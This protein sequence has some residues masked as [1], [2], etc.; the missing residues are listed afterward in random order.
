VRTFGRA[1]GAFRAG[2]ASALQA[3]ERVIP[4][5]AGLERFVRDERPDLLLVTPLIEL[6]SQQVDYVKCARRLGVR[7]AHCVASWDNL[8]SKGLIRVIPDHVVVWNEAQK[9]EAVTLHGVP[10]DRV[11]VT[12]AQ[13]FDDW[14]EA[15]PSRSRDAFCRDVGL[16]PSRP[17]VLYA[18][19]STFIAPDEVPFA[20]RWIATLRRSTDPVV[21]SAG[22]LIRP[23]PANAR[24]W[25]AFDRS[26]WPN[27]SL[28]PPVGSDANAPE[29]RRDYVDS[30]SHS[31]AVVGINTSA[32][33][34]AGI[35]GRP[36][37]TVCV[38]EFAHAQTG[39]L[40][41]QHLV[42]QQS[43]VVQPAATLDAHVE[44]LG[45][46]LNGRSRAGEAN[47]R[48]VRSFIRPFGEHVPAVPTFV[49]AIESLGSLPAPVP[50]LDSWRARAI[51]PFALVAAGAAH[52]LAEDRP[53][54]VYALRP[55]V[56]LAVWT[57]ALSHRARGAVR[58]GAYLRLKRLRRGIQRAQYEVP[59]AAG[60]IWRR[61]QKQ[62]RRMF[63]AAH[64]AHRRW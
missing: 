2:L 31:A 35:V 42:N 52:M 14:F 55:F 40:H 63:A 5:S 3:L 64:G 7:S 27:V 34:E 46:V 20:E 6:G 36:V 54:W 51:R 15:R 23:H 48:F 33:L 11:V 38:P 41:F 61:A 29:A 4:T 21:A 44:Q 18:G 25:R 50:R 37:F 47:A 22:V 59:R 19:S 8:T 10:P 17:F 43:G 32:Q 49:S 53:L 39:T 60:R 12:G 58:D 45:D 28:W 26:A 56:T 13:V 16:D 30:L 1:G 62:A 57:M 9:A 24:Q